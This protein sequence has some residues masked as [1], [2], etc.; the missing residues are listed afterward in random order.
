VLVPKSVHPAYRKTLHTI[1]ALQ[2]IEVVEFDFCSEGA[3]GGGIA[4]DWLARR[5]SARSP[6]W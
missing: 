4:P 5:I 3:S 1:V 2:N 6:R